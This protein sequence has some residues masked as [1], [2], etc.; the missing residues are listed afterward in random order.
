M[1]AAMV[2]LFLVAW[3]FATWAAVRDLFPQVLAETAIG[4]VV[5]CVV[6]FLL[7]PAALLFLTVC[8]AMRQ[9]NPKIVIADSGLTVHNWRRIATFIPWQYIVCLM[10][11]EHI[12]DLAWNVYKIVLEVEDGQGDLPG[13]RGYEPAALRG[14]R[15]HGIAGPR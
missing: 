14:C 2:G 5:P 6:F 1:Q 12:G 11:E 3:V 8:F 9:R 4:D 15:A 13:C 10:W 7:W